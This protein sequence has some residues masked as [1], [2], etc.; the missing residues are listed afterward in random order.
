MMIINIIICDYE[1]PN[2]G[3]MKKQMLDICTFGMIN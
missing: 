1:E 3:I 2:T